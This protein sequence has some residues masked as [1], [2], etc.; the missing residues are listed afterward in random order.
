MITAVP[1]T[2][3]RAE[4]PFV[5]VEGQ[6]FMVGD[7]P[8]YVCGT[9]LW[10]GA[11]LGRPSNP[12]GRA[13]LVRELD[14]LQALGVNN[15][16]VL[17]AAEACAVAGTLQP[18]IQTAPGE[19][20][21]DV[22]QGLDFLA[23]EAGKRGIRLVIFLNN[24]WDWSGGMP[25]YL[26]WVTGAPPVG[27]HVT[28]WKEFNRVLSTYYT[29][30]A[31]QEL[32]RRSI[33]MLLGRQNSITGRA[34]RD[35]PTI[36]AWELANEPRPG[37]FTGDNEAL[38]A[39]FVA[40]VERTA[41]YIHELAP[42]Q[43][44][45]TGSEGNMGCLNS[46]EGFRRVHAVK[47]I[48]YAVFHLWPKNWRWFDVNQ[49]A[50][51]IGTTI[52]KSRDYVRRHF[53][54]SARIGK[55]V[56]CEE[57][58][59]DR[60]GGFGVEVPTTARDRFYAEVFAL[61][62]QSIAEGGPAAG[63]NFWLWGGA[64]R[65]PQLADAPDG[66]GAGDMQQEEPGRNTV[67]DSDTST[68]GLLRGHFGRLAEPQALRGDA[69]LTETPALPVKRTSKVAY[70]TIDDGP[71]LSMLRKTDFL[72]AHGIPA[73]LFCTGRALDRFPDYAITAI[74]QGFVIGNHSYDH[75]F[76]SDLT[77]EQACE[78]IRRTDAII[79]ALYARAGVP[80]PAK[81]FRFPYGDKGALTHTDAFATP[82]AEGATRKAAIQKFLRGLGY[83]R[84]QFPGVTYDYWRNVLAADVD[85]Y[86]TYDV[87]EWSI[88]AGQPMYEVT[89]LA[90]VYARMEETVPEAGRGLNT[91]GSEEI[92][93][94]HDHPETDGLF[95]PIISRLLAKGM[96]FAG[97]K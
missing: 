14:R 47:G 87:M 22:L 12:V 62:E 33:A 38:M 45:T 97:P 48:D 31:A 81:F 6:R 77:P 80:R 24:Y 95:E 73:V 93:L 42:H 17:G 5:R 82:S 16:R 88:F 3:A 84:P 41:A 64:G 66:I 60:D 51:T 50:A 70:L 46:D 10:Y 94:T 69:G 53:A 26:S 13:R 23:A 71:S 29:N 19:Y 1:T 11:H 68:L 75:P 25:Q 57:F 2:V 37:E 44:V 78:Q 27:V 39:N 15:L 74:Q 96:H 86:W 49:H 85:W 52:E 91:P 65:P 72:R 63:S 83:T 67:F 56:V 35:D 79:D 8:M 4:E 20:S 58:G 40:W 89:S 92:I 30:S 21:E 61:I 59:L 43:L 18:A 7:Q 9:N 54:E 28:E 90:A 36:M 34:Y 55:P 76:F 32:N